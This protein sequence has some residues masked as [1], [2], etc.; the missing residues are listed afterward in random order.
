MDCQL[1]IVRQRLVLWGFLQMAFQQ[2]H[3]KS[4]L[5]IQCFGP[6][7]YFFPINGVLHIDDHHILT[8]KLYNR[9]YFGIVPEYLAKSF[10]IHLGLIVVEQPITGPTPHRSGRAELPHPALQLYIHSCRLCL[11]MYDN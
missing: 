7:K 5:Q 6:R 1:L 11:H 10:H 9:L 4:N 8:W 2:L 3:M